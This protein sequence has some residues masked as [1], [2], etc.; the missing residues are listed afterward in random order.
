MLVAKG[1]YLQLLVQD[2]WFQKRPPILQGLL[3]HLNQLWF[4]LPD[5]TRIDPEVAQ[6]RVFINRE[7]RDIQQGHEVFIP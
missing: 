4:A 7:F 1:F 6:H 5:G 3:D 2:L